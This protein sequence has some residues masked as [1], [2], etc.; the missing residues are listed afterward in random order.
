MRTTEC[1][2]PEQQP[3]GCV[4][5]DGKLWFAT[6]RGV[7]VIDPER[8]VNSIVPPPPVVIE[9]VLADG[10]KQA[11]SG[12]Y[13]LKPG[14]MR[15]TIQYTHMSLIAGTRNQFKYRLDGLD[16]DWVY[17]GSKRAAEY[18]HLSPG[19]YRF[20]VCVC[21]DDGVWNETGASM[22]IE[23]QTLLLPD[24]LVRPVWRWRG[25]GRRWGLSFADCMT[26]SDN[27]WLL[28][29]VPDGHLRPAGRDYRTCP[30]GGGLRQ[31]KA[32]EAAAPRVRSSPA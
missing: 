23:L 2:I 13:V 8:L 22:D 32:E 14:R 19:S 10:E 24:L 1:T 16:D 7:V 5:G 17:A 18:T 21:N 9:A 12:N 28:A 25:L 27:T 26:R 20:R 4:A 29:C 3:A 30:D 15:V 6:R 31:A 11:R